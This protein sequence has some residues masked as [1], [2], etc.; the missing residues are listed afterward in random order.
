[1][2]DSLHSCKMLVF[3]ALNA[4]PTLVASWD[5]VASWEPC[6][7]VMEVAIKGR[8]LPFGGLAWYRIWGFLL[9]DC[10][11]PVFKECS[12]GWFRNFDSE[13]MGDD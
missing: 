10:A 7:R 12:S 3:R 13:N 9:Y 11:A 1:M 6:R 4:K 8:G 5:A 2:D